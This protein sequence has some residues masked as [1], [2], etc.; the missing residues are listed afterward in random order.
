MKLLGRIVIVALL[1]FFLYRVLVWISTIRA[2]EVVGGGIDLAVDEAKLPNTLL[3]FPSE[4][5]RRELLFDNPILADIQFKK[6]YP[7]TLVIVPV[8]RTAVVR[9]E[10][11]GRTVLVDQSGI[12]LAD[13]DAASPNVP[14]FTIPISGL[15]IGQAISDTRVT[16][17]LAF[18]R[19]MRNILAISNISVEPDGSLRS[20]GDKPDIL[21]TQDTDIIQTLTTLQTLLAGFRI[22]GTLPALIDLRFDKPIVKF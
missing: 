20:K 2:I 16:Q 22:K 19:G 5:I 9:L 1:S 11:V 13:A 17:S 21:F 14:M 12:V 8:F 18:L 6:K 3:F 15:R 4:K 10:G 7:N